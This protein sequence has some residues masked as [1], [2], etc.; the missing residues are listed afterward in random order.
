MDWLGIAIQGG[1][2]GIAI[3]AL[4]IILRVVR[5]HRGEMKDVI[6]RNTGAMIENAK[7]TAALTASLPNVCRYD[8]HR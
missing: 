6:D 4:L 2:V 5:E 1:A 8:R 7:A 3:V